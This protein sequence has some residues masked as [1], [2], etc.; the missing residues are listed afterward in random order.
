MAT[1]SIKDLFFFPYCFITYLDRKS[2]VKLWR[3]RPKLLNRTKEKEW[4]LEFTFD[5]WQRF[6]GSF[7]K[8]KIRN[9]LLKNV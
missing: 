4:N 6:L 7:F 3:L 9:H 8:K 1:K 5:T 2:F